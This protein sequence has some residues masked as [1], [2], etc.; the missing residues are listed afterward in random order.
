MVDSVFYVVWLDSYHNLTNSEG[1]GGIQKFSATKLNY[2]QNKLRHGLNALSSRKFKPPPNIFGYNGSESRYVFNDC[3][4]S[5]NVDLH[6]LSVG[7]IVKR[8]FNLH[9]KKP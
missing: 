7:D 2:S 1:Y 6:N 5:G 9:C 3:V 8:Q 4:P